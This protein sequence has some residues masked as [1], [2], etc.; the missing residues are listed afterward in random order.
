MIFRSD[1]A[2][3]RDFVIVDHHLDDCPSAKGALL[4][5]ATEER[6]TIESNLFS[7][8]LIFRFTGGTGLTLRAVRGGIAY[9]QFYDLRIRYAKRGIHI[10]APSGAEAFVNSNHFHGGAIS[11]TPSDGMDFGVLNEGTLSPTTG[12]VN[13]ANQNTFNAMTIEPSKTLL[14]HVV[15]RGP[16]ASVAL[17][18][19]RLEASKQDADV[20]IVYVAPESGGTIITDT[21]VGHR[22]VV[23]DLLRNPGIKVW[24]GKTLTHAP[25]L[26]NRLL[27]P[28]FHPENVGP[29]N[30]DEAGAGV[31]LGLEHW[32][33]ELNGVK[34]Q[35]SEHSS[36]GLLTFAADPTIDGSSGQNAAGN[37]AGSS[38]SSVESNS[39]FPGFHPLTVTIPAGALVT[40]SPV[41]PTMQPYPVNVAFGVYTAAVV[42]DGED[43]PA[44]RIS[45]TMRGPSGGMLSSSP[46]PA[47]GNWR[48]LGLHAEQSTSVGAAAPAP[49]IRLNNSLGVAAATVVLTAPSLGYGV[50]VVAG[51]AALQSTGGL[52]AGTL[53]L[54]TVPVIINSCT[55]TA[56]AGRLT[57]PV[58]G[59]VFDIGCH[60]CDDDHPTCSIS[61]INAKT[62]DRFLPGTIIT[63][64]LPEAT[65]S[66]VGRV[67]FIKGAYIDLLSQNGQPATGR[68]TL[69]L[70][71]GSS[72]TWREISRATADQWS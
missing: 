9:N 56:S 66:G 59:N 18:G 15:V 22:H 16:A 54:A 10:V 48:Y 43:L 40:L 57:L 17:L 21:M 72:G 38:T 2:G 24:S 36:S 67:S 33:V 12:R 8:I 5:E 64:L 52:M 46:Q 3:G 20:P 26:A 37:A 19:C 63:L 6:P 4:L 30:V 71:A 28:S 58:R 1:N 61:R 68:W 7:N 70:V 23:A 45:A 49:T 41:A 35:A 13:P 29:D 65:S 25:S 14:G 44:V 27:N 42:V 62:G 50:Q 39:L 34:V 51:E 69:T 11:G 55:L 47:D 60:A 32:E 53:T 31:G